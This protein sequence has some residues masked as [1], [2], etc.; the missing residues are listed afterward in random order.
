MVLEPGGLLV[1]LIVGAI[2]GWL[3]GQVMSGGGFGLIGDVIVGLIGAFIGGILFS[4]FLPGVVTGFVGSILVA[5]AGAV[6]LL[7]VLR[8][9]SPRRRSIL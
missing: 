4:Q 7:A 6:V 3:A 5:F 2:A 9:L 8:L 1:W